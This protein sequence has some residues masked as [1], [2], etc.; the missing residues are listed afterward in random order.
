[1]SDTVTAGPDVRLVLISDLVLDPAAQPRSRIDDAT[2][3]EYREAAAAGAKFTPPVVAFDDGDRLWVGD[4]FHRVLATRA[5]GLEVIEAEVRP[6]TRRDAVLYS[7]GANA[8]HGLKRSPADKRRAVATLLRDAEWGLWSDREVARRAGVS[9]T[10]VGEVR[11]ELPPDDPRGQSG[12]ESGAVDYPRG[13][14]ENGDDPTGATIHVD[15]QTGGPA[16]ARPRKGADGRVTD[17]ARIGR[18]AAAGR[19]RVNGVLAD[20][21]PDVAA[22]RAAGRLEAGVV[23]EVTEPEPGAPGAGREPGEDDD[24]EPPEA[25]L[26]DDDWLATLPL[27]GVLGGGP[28]RTFHADALVYRRLESHRKTFAYHAS[29]AIPAAARRGAFAWH[30]K[31]FLAVNHPA[32]WLA[33]PAEAEGGCGGSGASP[34]G[35]CPKCHG[36]GYWILGG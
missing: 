6:G 10:Y 11:R 26:S 30:V 32:R 24:R 4:G 1:M 13:Q 22:A 5:A 33:C 9:P 12:D 35:D 36:R 17:T 18:P 28:L 19:S 7:C 16:P 14:S 15:S 27:S 2:V 29:R 31:R 3:E 25:E 20:D 34:F 23:P 21:P 8:F